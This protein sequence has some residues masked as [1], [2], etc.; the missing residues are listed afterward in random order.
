[1]DVE[2]LVKIELGQ[3][4]SR[5]DLVCPFEIEPA[6][7]MARSK[8]QQEKYAEQT[9]DQATH[10]SLSPDE[11]RKY[12]ASGGTVKSASRLKK[13]ASRRVA[14]PMTAESLLDGLDRFHQAQGRKST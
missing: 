12:S 14:K 6:E 2:E 5:S 9:S 11:K 3:K 13:P 4:S 8:Y 7:A 10:S 1:V